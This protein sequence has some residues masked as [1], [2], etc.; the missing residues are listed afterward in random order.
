MNTSA[1]LRRMLRLPA[2]RRVTFSCAVASAALLLVADLPAQ[3]ATSLA[4]GAIVSVRVSST[5]SGTFLQRAR[6][7]LVPT[8]REAVADQFGV[9][10]FLGV[11]PGSYS[12]RVAYEGFPETVVPVRVT[13]S[14]RVE[15]PIGLKADAPLQLDQFV[16]TAEREG[17]AAALTRQKNARSVENVVAMDALGVL[18]NDNP[19]EVLM[20]L[21]GIYALP[22]TEGNF[23]RPVIR[24]LPGELNSTTVDGG[25]LASQFAM[26]RSAVYTNITANN[27]DEIQVTKALTPDLPASSV[28][29]RVNFKTKTALNLKT[30]R[31]L[32]YRL[33]GKWSPTIFDFT[34]RRFAPEAL[35]NFSLSY[36]EVF[37]LF[38]EARN[39]GVGANAVYN[40]NIT[41]RT[42]TIANLDTS[43]RTPQF[44][45]RFQRFDGI[46]DRLLRTANVRGD[47]R[48]SPDARF[49]FNLMRNLQAQRTARPE[50]YQVDYLANIAAAG[51]AFATSV[52]PTGAPLTGGN[53]KPGSTEVLTEVLPSARTT[54]VANTNPFEANDQTTFHQFGGEQR[55]GAWRLDYLFGYS[56]AERNTARRHLPNAGRNFTASVANVGW[57][58]DKT[59]GADFPKFTQTAGPSIFDPRN[60]TGAVVSQGGANARNHSSSGEFNVKRDVILGGRALQL[61][62]GGAG[63]RQSYA[64]DNFNRQFTYAGPDGVVGLNPVTRVNDDDLTRFA[65][66]PRLEPRLGFGPLPAFDPNK[67]N[68]SIDHEPQLWRTDPYRELSTA[69]TTFSY[70]Q[71]KIRAAYVMGGTRF[72]SLGVLGGVRWEESRNLS[73][74]YIQRGTFASITDLQARVNA[75]YG[76][77]PIVR[78]GQSDGFFPSIHFRHSFTPNLIGRASFSTGIGRPS[79][80]DLVPNFAVNDTQREVTIDNPSIKPMYA[81]NYDVALEYYLQPMGRIGVTLFRKDL[82]DFVFRQEVGIVASGADNGYGG[83]Y[84]GYDI[85]SNAN[86]GGGR[87]DGFEF[88]YLQQLTFLPGAFR[89][90]TLLVNYTRLSAQGDY[91]QESGGA[92]GLVGFVPD[93]AN[94]RLSYNYRW[95]APYV[96]W[97]YVGRTLGSFNVLPQLQTNRLERR[98]VNVG[99]SVRLPRHVELFLD[100]SNLFDEP[101]RT[102]H[103]VT[104]TRISTIYNGPFVSFGLNGRY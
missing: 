7:E 40:E 98:I 61:S 66:S 78:R 13:G 27:F 52:S 99:A 96:Q 30:K 71:E 9:A 29:G 80:G 43:A 31:E 47:F 84:S 23:D 57:I 38:G 51:R 26:T 88:E 95:L 42:R 4:G 41:Q 77:D 102:A 46:Q 85:I 35:P 72:G 54:F 90:L 15:V 34:P 65:S 104:G 67:Y 36:R 89:G 75:E 69:R 24:G 48:L 5:D 55:L 53:I 1:H 62:A 19:A 28:S 6:V 74:G 10:E 91:G 70:V 100:V 45:E 49:F 39:F 60:Y 101:Q 22:S 32:T 103:F 94:V 68:H 79:L 87:V 21:P 76:T 50:N 86:G 12:V 73:R 92:G 93:T 2:S 11:A 81:D 3:G 59:G 64:Q 8:G 33:G 83:L 56:R 20:R 25:L 97:S 14:G 58:L 44:T 82:S 63:T 16:V 18:A 37:D 17:N